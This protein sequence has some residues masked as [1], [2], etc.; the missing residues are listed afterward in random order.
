VAPATNAPVAR[1]RKALAGSK[2][3]TVTLPGSRLTTVYRPV[4]SVVAASV[5]A[6]DATLT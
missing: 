6:P 4:A 3:I 1:L 2:T 5:I